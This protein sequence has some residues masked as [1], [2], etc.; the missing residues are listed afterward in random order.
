MEIHVRYDEKKEKWL[1]NSDIECTNCPFYERCANGRII[2][3]KDKH[4]ERDVGSMTGKTV[5]FSS[6]TSFPSDP[7]SPL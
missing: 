3:Y 7:S 1:C 6:F 2:I 5:S 4:R